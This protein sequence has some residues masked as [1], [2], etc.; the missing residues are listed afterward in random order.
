[1]VAVQTAALSQALAGIDVKPEVIDQVVSVLTSTST[2]M[3]GSEFTADVS[4]PRTDFGDRPS[5]TN[6]GKHFEMA[7]AAT[8]EAVDALVENINTFAANAK[9]AI[10]Y[11]QDTDGQS[12]AELAKA[13]AAVEQMDQ[14]AA[15]TSDGS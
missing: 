12:A 9:T 15:N 3:G 10:T 5:A 8:Q 11:V 14:T 13:Q 7:I 6:L 1:M 2:D 4:I